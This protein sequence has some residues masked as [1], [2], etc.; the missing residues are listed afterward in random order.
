MMITMNEVEIFNL[1]T[2][3]NEILN[4]VSKKRIFILNKKLLNK[5]ISKDFI[6]YFDKILIPRN[7]DEMY[8]EELLNATNKVVKM[9]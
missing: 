9:L 4:Q 8:I 6:D 5:S 7:N 2:D 1:S 3:F